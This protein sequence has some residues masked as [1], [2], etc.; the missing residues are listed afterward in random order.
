MQREKVPPHGY[1]QSRGAVA[2]LQQGGRTPGGGV[3]DASKRA[4]KVRPGFHR[5]LERE[6]TDSDR[7]GAES[8]IGFDR[9]MHLDRLRAGSYTLT[10]WELVQFL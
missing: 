2:Q 4:V 3:S 10:V 9:N 5:R 6:E 7:L 1:C 8:V